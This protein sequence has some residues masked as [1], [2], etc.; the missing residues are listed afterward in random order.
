VIA[1]FEERLRQAMPGAV[2]YNMLDEY[3]ALEANRKGAFTPALKKRLTML[4][5][6]A[7]KAKPTLLVSTCSTLSRHLPPLCARIDL[8]CMT[9]DAEMIDQAVKADAPLTVLATAPS[10]VKPLSEGLQAAAEQ[11]GKQLMLTAL[12]CPEAF[13]TLL[14]KG[15]EAH[16]AVLL[17][18]AEGIHPEGVVLLAQASMAHLA[19][20]LQNKLGLPV[21]SA[22]ELCVQAIQRKLARI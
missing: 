6:S 14:L 1:P 13:R 22:P 9:I 15:R 5:E 12:V 18:W 10:A 20:P 4:L 3:M 7:A 17:K 2:V 21:M 11:A 8:Q 16:D 19:K